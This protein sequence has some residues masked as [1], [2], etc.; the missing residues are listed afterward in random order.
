MT[1]FNKP[2]GSTV[3]TP[4]PWSR[5][6]SPLFRCRLIRALPRSLGC[7]E[8]VGDP[9][10]RQAEP[11]SGENISSLWLRDG[12]LESRQHSCFARPKELRKPGV[13]DIFAIRRLWALDC[14]VD[15]EPGRCRLQGLNPRKTRC[16]DY[17][18]ESPGRT[19]KEPPSDSTK[20][21]LP[22]KAATLPAPAQADGVH[23]SM[24]HRGRGSLVLQ[25]LARDNVRSP[26]SAC[27][28]HSMAATDGIEGWRG[29]QNLE[30]Y[31][32][33]MSVMNIV[34]IQNKL[35]PM[36]TILPQCLSQRRRWAYDSG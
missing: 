25:V 8:V 29:T 22:P 15:Q 21:S 31:Y 23:Q 17:L 6:E 35:Q 34:V 26:Q 5:A 1:R 12:L 10:D 20:W 27:I 28:T 24:G 16:A 7:Q 14:V 19:A 13:D 9:A 18:A 4:P 30:S 36:Q 33:E 3:A 2:A 11:C 32:P